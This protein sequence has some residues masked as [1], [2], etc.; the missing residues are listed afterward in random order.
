[1]IAGALAGGPVATPPSQICAA[2]H[3]MTP[4]QPTSPHPTSAEQESRGQRELMC[5]WLEG[6]SGRHGVMGRAKTAAQPQK[7]GIQRPRTRK[8]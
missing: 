3:L 2:V 4:G 8:I 1:M 6:L 7:D 5:N